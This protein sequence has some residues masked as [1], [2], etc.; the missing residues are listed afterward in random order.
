MRSLMW[1]LM[2]STA[3]SQ[4]G[5]SASAARLPPGD[6]PPPFDNCQFDALARL[7][8]WKTRAFTKA[9]FSM[10]PANPEHAEATQLQMIKERWMEPREQGYAVLERALKGQVDAS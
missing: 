1:S 6:G 10:D 9:L 7:P 3:F 8:E 2:R 4:T 5:D